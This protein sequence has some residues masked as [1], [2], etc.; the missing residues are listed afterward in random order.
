LAKNQLFVKCIIPKFCCFL[1]T[2]VYNELAMKLIPRPFGYLPVFIT[3][4]LVF[5]A[6]HGLANTVELDWNYLGFSR[7]QIT[8]NTGDEVDIANV[9]DTFDLQLTGAPAPNNFYADVPPFDGMYYY[10]VPHVYSGSGTFTLSDE[11]GDVATVIVNPATPLSVSITAP[12]NNAVFTAPATFAITAVPAGGATPYAQ[13]QFFAGTNLNAVAYGAS[14]ASAITNLPAGTYTISAVVTDNNFNTATNSITVSVA[15]SQA[16]LTGDWPTYGNG[17]AHTGYL[18]GK[19]NGLPFVLKWKSPMQYSQN[20]YGNVLSQAAIGGGRLYVSV[21]YYS[22]G[23]SVRALDANTG[24]PLWTNWPGVVFLGP[25]TYDSGAVFVQQDNGANTSSYLSSFDAAT[26][27]T[28]W[29]APYVSQV[30]QHMA[31]VAAGGMIFADTGYYHGLTG[32][33]EA[34]GYQQWFVQLGGSDQWTPA[35]YNGE[36]YTWLG[37]FTE[38]DPGTGN[39]NWTLTNG[40]A[41]AASSRTVAVADGRAYFIGDSLYCVDLA[42]QTNAW[43]VSGGFSG[44]PAIANGIVYAISNKVVCAFTTNGVFVRQY[45][46]N[47]G[48]YE[49]IFGPLIVTDDVLIATGEYGVYVFRLADGAV[50][51][52]ISSYSGPPYYLYYGDTV[53]LANNTLYVTST[54]GNVYAYTPASTT[55]I[56]LGS[57]TKLGNGSFQFS[58]TNTPGATFTVWGSTNVALAASNWAKL[59]Y[60]TNVTAGQYQFTDTNAPVNAR[61]FYRVSSP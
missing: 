2:A 10:Y 7:S 32:F 45:D 42:T 58:F 51:Q 31:P 56:T 57:A 49:N 6:W 59:G 34:G 29:S 43:S 38:W 61:C 52:Q 53:T 26:G 39:A 20:S 4:L 33:D 1:L 35:Y 48:G 37:S 3:S 36:V 40:V 27:Y 47:P 22:S 11:F 44:T 46:A 19:L 50:Q 30:Y 23:I 21:G 17:P 9:D 12:T 24:E 41:G 18:P 60:V 13:V 55:A 8:I 28:N 25:P 14:F 5:T 16:T 15:P 54:D